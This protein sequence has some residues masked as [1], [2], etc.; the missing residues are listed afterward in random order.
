VIGNVTR[1]RKVSGLLYY[2]FG[3]GRANEHVDPHIVAG[4]R[5]PQSLEPRFRPDGRRDFSHL[6]RVL[7]LPLAA[8]YGRAP[9]S[10]VWHCSVRAAPTD[11]VLSDEEWADVAREVMHQTGQA[12]RHADECPG[13]CS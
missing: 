8:L 7:T 2:L 13:C 4:F 11:R 5:M 9:E 3:P 6:T 12:G 1:G 10:P